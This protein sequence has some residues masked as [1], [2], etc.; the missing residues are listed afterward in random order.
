MPQV[1]SKAKFWINSVNILDIKPRGNGLEN[2]VQHNR[3]FKAYFL[4]FPPYP[5]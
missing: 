4:Y 5:S 1:E 3:Q 2:Y